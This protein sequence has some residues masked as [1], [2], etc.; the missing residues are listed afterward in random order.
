[1]K[2]AWKKM[3]ICL[4]MFI[5]WLQ[6]TAFLWSAYLAV[7]IILNSGHP[8]PY[9]PWLI[10]GVILV[11]IGFFTAVGIGAFRKNYLKREKP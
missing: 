6:I 11:V 10:C 9:H 4:G 3:V 7:S 8:W 5:L 2:P 1:M